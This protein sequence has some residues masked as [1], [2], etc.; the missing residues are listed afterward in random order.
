M[1]LYDGFPIVRFEGD[2][3]A[4][5]A[6][7]PEG[8]RLLYQVQQVVERAK[9]PIYS[10]TEKFGDDSYITA[11][12]AG[13]TRVIL[14]SVNP[15]T[16]EDRFELSP[17][18]PLPDFYSGVVWKSGKLDTVEDKSVNPPLVY[19]VVSEFGPTAPCA[20][21]FAPKDAF[22]KKPPNFARQKNK[23]LAVRASTS[24]YPEA[25]VAS[26]NFETSLFTQL[27]PSMWTGTMAKVVSVMFGYGFMPSNKRKLPDGKTVPQFPLTYDYKWTRTH[28]VY[29][30]RSADNKIEPWLIE[31]SITRGVIAMPLRLFP[32]TKSKAGGDGDTNRWAQRLKNNGYGD[33]GEQVVELLGGL[34]T[35]AAFPSGADLDAAI[36]DGTVLQLKTAEELAPF[37]DGGSYFSSMQ[38]WCFNDK[39]NEAHNITWKY[40]TDGII[41]SSAY[42]ISIDIDP[43]KQFPLGRKPGEKIA[44]A[45]ATFKL[46]R[47]G[48]IWYG[49]KTRPLPVKFWEPFANNGFG[50]LLSFFGPNEEGRYPGDDPSCPLQDTPIWIGFQNNQAK[51][52]SWYYNNATWAAT[53]KSSESSSATPNPGFP[54]DPT[55]GSEVSFEGDPFQCRF[56]NSYSWHSKEGA[57]F[58]PPFVYTTDVDDRTECGDRES[59]YYYTSKLIAQYKWPIECS[60]SLERPGW[61]QCVQWEGYSTEYRREDI[62]GRLSGS[63]VVFPA[64]SRSGYYYAWGEMTPQPYEH[65]MARPEVFYKE[66]AIW[67]RRHTTS[68]SGHLDN[69][70]TNG[71]RC[72][73]QAQPNGSYEDGG[74]SVIYLSGYM[75]SELNTSCK[76]F[77]DSLNPKVDKVRRVT[78]YGCSPF[79]NGGSEC[80]G[81]G[82]DGASFIISLVKLCDDW[83]ASGKPYAIGSFDTWVGQMRKR[84]DWFDPVQWNKTLPDRYQAR[85]AYYASDGNIHPFTITYN[86]FLNYQITSSPTPMGQFQRMW[87]SEAVFGQYGALLSDN[88]DTRGGKLVTKGVVPTYKDDNG[89]LDFG[90]FIGVNAPSDD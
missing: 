11:M 1:A 6:L 90:C 12:H 69:P 86:D 87:A 88:L 89:A 85:M 5:L 79:Y 57:W 73:A 49:S 36:A 71:D 32:Q 84:G 43:L 10:L 72:T 48:R 20:E 33:A 35:G 76:P 62:E 17:D 46:T 78:S 63:A 64:Y 34:P 70:F 18:G 75:Q 47:K 80:A 30:G 8:K 40:D 31:I 27:R 44:T 83:E 74:V 38:G 28:G 42:Q 21:Y 9:I 67:G 39:G 2:R 61:F 22:G 3:Q 16:S 58:V 19:K 77:Y 56:G 65:Y 60:D 68:L 23:R 50:A 29:I 37:Y 24:A 13:T 53:N 15:S 81:V 55:P 51:T 4:G 14:I 26:R 52:V 25:Y 66:Q 59:H 45:T 41:T 7:V 54:S 82:L